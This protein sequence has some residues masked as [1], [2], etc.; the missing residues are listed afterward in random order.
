[1]RT[2][3]EEGR[4]VHEASIAALWRGAGGGSRQRG[5]AVGMVESVGDA[6]REAGI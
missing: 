2:R 4:G 3:R 5:W 1:M 6:S